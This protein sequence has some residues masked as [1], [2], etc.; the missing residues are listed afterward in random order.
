M[1]IKIKKIGKMF[2]IK[3]I[4][5]ENIITRYAKANNINERVNMLCQGV[6]NV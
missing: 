1:I 4:F 2:E 3:G 5:K 6:F